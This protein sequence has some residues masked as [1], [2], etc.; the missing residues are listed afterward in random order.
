M[1]PDKRKI[2]LS[3]E[4]FILFVAHHVL[5]TKRAACRMLLPVDRLWSFVVIN[6]CK[7]KEEN[8]PLFLPNTWQWDP[9]MVIYSKENESCHERRPDE[10]LTSFSAFPLVSGNAQ[11]CFFDFFCCTFELNSRDNG[12]LLIVLSTS[13]HNGVKITHLTSFCSSHAII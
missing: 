7:R 12:V 9:L 5:K 8:A 13:Q 1:P 3:A 11:V 10:I 4:D 6:H 2:S